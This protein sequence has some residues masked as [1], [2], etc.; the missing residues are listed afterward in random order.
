MKLTNF[1][2]NLIT[3]LVIFVVGFFVFKEFAPSFIN[4]F[5]QIKDLKGALQF[6]K[7]ANKDLKEQN[8]NILSE[9]TT[10][11]RRL[12]RELEGI[13][14]H[15]DSLKLAVE[16]LEGELSAIHTGEGDINIGGAVEV[17]VT[18]SVVS[19]SDD[20]I[21]IKYW[22]V[23][24]SLW[25]NLQAFVRLEG[26]EKTDQ[27]GNRRQIENVWLES[28][29][30]KRKIAIPW[31]AHYVTYKPKVRLW[32]WWNPKL[33][34]DVLFSTDPLAY[35]LSFNLASFGL[36]TYVETTYFYIANFGIASN[37]KDDIRLMFFPVKYNLGSSIPLITNLNTSLGLGWKLGSQSN[38]G[39][40]LSI[41]F[42]H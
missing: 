12:E 9:S 32:H 34:S 21:T 33:Q 41:G 23:N 16:Y 22:P 4:P 1:Q 29:T 42:V 30:S 13:S 2:K 37:F 7:T 19:A 25:W 31:K 8:A 3:T 35:G 11:K 27:Y 10:D 6:T 15:N 36:G 24:D 39:V 18:D 5:A 26:V 40:Y 20:F 38:F 17:V 14:Q 28:K